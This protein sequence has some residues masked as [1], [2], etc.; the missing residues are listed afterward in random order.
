MVGIDL[1]VNLDDASVRFT[2][3]GRI[4]VLD[5]IRALTFS[6]SP[7]LIWEDLKRGHPE[8]VKHS[9]DHAFREGGSSP[10]L[11]SEG[12]DMIWALLFEHVV[13]PGRTVFEMMNDEG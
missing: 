3:D 12:W 6:N 10:V 2:P 11:D 13:D 9:R 7:E 1:T 8:I 5:A 4:S